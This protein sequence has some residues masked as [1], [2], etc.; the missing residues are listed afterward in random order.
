MPTHDSSDLVAFCP[1]GELLYLSNLT[2]R[3]CPA[4]SSAISAKAP[5]AGRSTGKRRKDNTS[6]GESREDV[7]H[8]RKGMPLTATKAKSP[9]SSTTA[10]NAPEKSND[11]NKEP[12]ETRLFIK[13]VSGGEDERRALV[14]GI[15]RDRMAECSDDEKYYEAK[16]DLYRF[17]DDQFEQE[18]E[19]PEIDSVEYEVVIKTAATGVNVGHVKFVVV[20]L[21]DSEFHDFW[22]VFQYHSPVMH[23]FLDVFAEEDPV[24][25]RGSYEGGRSDGPLLKIDVQSAGTKCWSRHEFTSNSKDPLVYILELIVKDE[26]RGRGI[27]TQVYETLSSLKACRGAKYF[28]AE[29]GPIDRMPKGESMKDWIMR[30]RRIRAFHRQVGFRRIGNSHFF[31]RAVDAQHPSGAIKPEN[32]AGYVPVGDM[33]E[34]KRKATVYAYA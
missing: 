7:K 28:F 4:M 26:W 20:D 6:D 19:D 29:P 3:T 10:G 21:A 22:S 14:E 16:N 1:H 15:L 34:A 8:S 27:G 2:L 25:Y 32:D 24:Y 11:E 30:G 17:Q 23:R 12:V 18:E 31:A 33:P 5:G 13:K 9:S